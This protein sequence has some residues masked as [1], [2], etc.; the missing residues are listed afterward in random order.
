MSELRAGDIGLE[1]TISEPENIPVIRLSGF[2]Y[3]LSLLHDFAVLLALPEFA[4]YRFDQYF[5][6][7]RGRPLKSD[8][9]FLLHRLEYGSPLKL[10]T[11]V[12]RIAVIAGVALVL[13]QGLEMVGTL[14]LQRDKMR[15]EI[16]HLVAQTELARAQTATIY[17]EMGLKE[18]AE[19]RGPKAMDALRRIYGRLSEY[20][21]VADALRVHDFGQHR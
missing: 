11:A 10:D 21:M 1:L 18:A 9:I 13:V 14:D 16:E 8:Q 12:Q 17:G 20:E 7:R 4:D 5:W 3:D 19:G 15:A 6:L 2:L